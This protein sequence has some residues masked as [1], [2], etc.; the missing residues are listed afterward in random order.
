MSHDILK[1]DGT[2]TYLQPQGAAGRVYIGKGV[3]IDPAG[4]IVKCQRGLVAA[5]STK[6]DAAPIG[7]E[8]NVFETVGSGQGAILSNVASGFKCT[9]VNMGAN[10]LKVYPPVGGRFLRSAVD[11]S[12]SVTSPLACEF[13]QLDKGTD[14]ATTVWDARALP[15]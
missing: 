12:F 15:L 7:S 11:A 1:T 9:V 14:L 3:A 6:T 5:G 8:Y 2:N 4:T 10:A 13:H